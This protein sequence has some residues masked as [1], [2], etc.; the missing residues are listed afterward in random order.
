M[1]AILCFVF[2]KDFNTWHFLSEIGWLILSA[3]AMSVLGVLYLVGRYNVGHPMNS[4]S[5]GSG[6][7]DLCVIVSG[8]YLTVTD[9]Q[10]FI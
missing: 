9:V 4:A 8:W 2:E 7:K 5:L 10:L 6:I 1:A 3:N